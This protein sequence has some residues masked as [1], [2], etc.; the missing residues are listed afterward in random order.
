MVHGM[1]SVEGIEV[2]IDYLRFVNPRLDIK[3]WI[4][5]QRY[6]KWMY[7][8]YLDW[9]NGHAAKCGRYFELSAN[10][11]CGS[12]FAAANFLSN[13]EV[14]CMYQLSGKL[15]AKMGVASHRI[16]IKRFMEWGFHCTRIDFCCDDF[17]WQL[18]TKDIE[19]AIEE[20]NIKYTKVGTIVKGFYDSSFTY[21]F[22]RRSS[23]R[24]GRIYNKLA[25]S[26]GQRNCIRL[27]T[28]LKGQ[29]AKKATELI[30]SFGDDIGAIVNTIRGLALS[31]FEF[32]DRKADTNINRCPRLSWWQEFLDRTG[33]SIRVRRETVP[34]SI[35]RIRGWF[36]KQ[37]STSLATVRRAIGV[38]EFLEWI[39][40]Q[41]EIGET[42]IKNSH[43][44][45][46]DRYHWEQTVWSVLT[47]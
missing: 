41:I 40:V 37:V 46:V 14:D 31:A 19:K 27:E 12:G 33:E 47:T 24:Y 5:I 22:G 34:S 16:I 36:G 30:K 10:T 45:I 1:S 6:M 28:E 15:M 25:E 18:N 8:I 42:K 35:E 20:K 43:Q 4:L 9:E 39:T 32:V 3:D 13:G 7:G 44:Q 17:D 26:N 11:E 29:L 21:G 38:D 23:E 2:G